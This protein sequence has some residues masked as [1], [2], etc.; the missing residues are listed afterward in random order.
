VV[1]ARRADTVRERRHASSDLPDDDGL[2]SQGR[3]TRGRL[4]DAGMTVLADKGYHVAR[5]DDIVKAAKVS[6]GTFYLYFANKQELLRALA[7]QCA[8]EMA[9]VVS[10]LGAVEPGAAGRRVV[11]DWLAEFVDTYARYGVVIRSWMEDTTTDREL[12]QLGRKTFGLLTDALVARVREARGVRDADAELAAAA[13]LAL[14][15]RHT[16]Y[17]ISRGGTADATTLDTLAALVH[18]GWFG[19]KVART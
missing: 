12:L 18:R 4:L 19:G 6:H 13:L 11:R 3:R 9:G 10:G 7:G 14:I 16:Y 2:R 8:D 17:V 1:A 15:E 5:V